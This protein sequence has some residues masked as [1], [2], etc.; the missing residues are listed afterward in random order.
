V[1]GTVV[2]KNPFFP[3]TILSRMNLLCQACLKRF[4]SKKKPKLGLGL[5]LFNDDKNLD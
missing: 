2:G 4:K 1:S 3:T 5:F